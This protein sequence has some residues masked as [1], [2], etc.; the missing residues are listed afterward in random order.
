MSEKVARSSP[1]QISAVMGT[2]RTSKRPITLIKTNKIAACYPTAT[3]FI[4]IPLIMKM[5]S[6]IKN[7]VEVPLMSIKTNYFVAPKDFS[8]KV[9][10]N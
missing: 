2:P 7:R 3:R 10:H 9:S 6:L 1:Y 8:I 5:I 4:I